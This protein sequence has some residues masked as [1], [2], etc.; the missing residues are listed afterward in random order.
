MDVEQVTRKLTEA[1]AALREYRQ[2]HQRRSNLDLAKIAE[3]VENP[4]I[5]T[6]TEELVKEAFLL[7]PSGQVCPRCNGSG[8][9]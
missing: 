5:R 2:S 9:I 8:T 7:G 3:S 4:K 6:I 1:L